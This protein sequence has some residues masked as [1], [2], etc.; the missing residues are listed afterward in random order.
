MVDEFSA[1]AVPGLI[2]RDKRGHDVELPMMPVSV[3]A[4]SQ[5][6]RRAARSSAQPV[7]MQPVSF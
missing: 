7:V 2:V 4:Q 3:G 5:L 6:L 1:N